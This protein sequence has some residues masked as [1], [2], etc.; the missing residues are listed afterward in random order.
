MIVYDYYFV[1]VARRDWKRIMTTCASV[2]NTSVFVTVL[3]NTYVYTLVST[4]GSI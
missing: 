4:Y 2:L 3:L 1:Y